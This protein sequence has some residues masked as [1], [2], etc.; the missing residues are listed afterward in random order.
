MTNITNYIVNV[1]EPVDPIEAK[2]IR[3]QAARYSVVA[4]ELYRRGFSTPLLKCIDQQ[5]ADYVLREIH[6]GI[7]GSH[8]GARTLT[9]KVLRAGYYWPTLKTDCAEYVKK[10]KQCQQ[11]GNL[12]H[13]STEQLHAVNAPWPF[14]LWGIDILGPFPLTKGQ[15]KFL[16]VA[17]DY[18]TKWIEAEPLA[19]ITSAN[20][21]KFV[22]KNIIT[23]FGIPYAIISDNGLQFTDKK[24]NNFLEN[25]GIQHQFT[26]VEHP[27]SNGQAEAA[28]KVVLTELKKRLGMAKGAWAEELPKVLWAYRCT[29]QSCTKETPFR[30]AYGT[31]AMIPVEVGEPSF[32]RTHFHEESN[33]GAIRA[34]LDVVEEL[35]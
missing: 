20:I 8:S 28:N 27:Q 35:R 34:E 9:A 6:E 29:P 22:W 16:V 10:C 23:R 30:L 18:F 19:T 31:D 21:Q 7:C 1:S 25:L 3:T 14:A 5:Q 12:I 11:H 17:V 26:S 33:D 13:A 2:K 4:G 32:R 15:C 24:F